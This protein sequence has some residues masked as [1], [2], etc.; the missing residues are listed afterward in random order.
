MAKKNV[1]TISG[2]RVEFSDGWG[3]VR[4]SSNLPKLVLV[5]EAKTQERMEAIKKEFAEILKKY[6]EVGEIEEE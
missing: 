2:A 5:F 4:A 3:L 1:N 6:P